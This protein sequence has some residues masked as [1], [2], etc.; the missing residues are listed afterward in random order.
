MAKRKALM[1][2]CDNPNC[3]NEMETSRD[4]PALGYYLGAG[5][6]HLGYGGGPIPATYACSTTCITPAVEARI[7][8]S[9]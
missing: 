8:A 1:M 4:D 9:S 3:P 6:W 7:E 2:Q 5:A